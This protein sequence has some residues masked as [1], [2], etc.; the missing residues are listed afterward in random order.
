MITGDMYSRTVGYKVEDEAE[1][2][3]LQYGRDKSLN[4]AQGVSTTYKS[5]LC[6]V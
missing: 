6:N 4:P 2:G 1:K 3:T 5:G